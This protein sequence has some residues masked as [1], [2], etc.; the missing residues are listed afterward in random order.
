MIHS[1]DAGRSDLLTI[2][3]LSLPETIVHQTVLISNALPKRSAK[4]P[5]AQSDGVF[6]LC[7]NHGGKCNALFR[8][9]T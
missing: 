5:V 4:L 3:T 6:G 9:T 2:A 7:Q 1:L 8:S